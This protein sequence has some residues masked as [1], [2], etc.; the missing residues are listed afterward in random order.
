[1]NVDLL[2]VPYDTALRGRR[3][4]AGPERLVAAGLTSRLEALGY[5]VTL[6]MVEPDVTFRPRS[7]PL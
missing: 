3:M 5:T 2:L 6:S 1:M 7:E 4:G